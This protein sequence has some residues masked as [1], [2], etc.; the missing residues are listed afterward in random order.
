MI[1]SN[2]E[3]EVFS[4]KYRYKLNWIYTNNFIYNTRT[5]NL[6]EL[7]YGWIA[8]LHKFN[9]IMKTIVENQVIL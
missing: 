2:A 1:L 5:W 3:H 4:T 7:I 9:T 8:D 6:E